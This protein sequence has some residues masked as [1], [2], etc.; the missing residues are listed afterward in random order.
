MTTTNRMNISM[1]DIAMILKIY[2]CLNIW[3]TKQMILIMPSINMN[4]ALIMASSKLMQ[5]F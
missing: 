1:V 2:L 4:L 3:Q 5:H